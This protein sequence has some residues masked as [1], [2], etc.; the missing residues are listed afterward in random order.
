MFLRVGFCGAGEPVGV[1]GDG[2]RWGL[3]GG[4]S[5]FVIV[6]VSS[7]VGDATL[8]TETSAALSPEGEGSEEGT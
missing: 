8:E 1:R 2:G 7:L 3:P 4:A 5:L 6:A